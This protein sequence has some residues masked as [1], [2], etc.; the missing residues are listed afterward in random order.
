MHRLALCLLG[1]L[2]GIGLQAA[3]ADK[4]REI[5]LT[6]TNLAGRSSLLVAT[7]PAGFT[8]TIKDMPGSK[9]RWQALSAESADQRVQLLITLMPPEDVLQKDA[10]GLEML[11]HK[12]SAPFVGGSVEG[13]VTPLPLK[14]TH[15]IGVATIFSDKSEVG[16]P[17]AKGR[18]HYK[19][20]T[21]GIIRVGEATLAS[22]TIFSDSKEAAGYLDALKLVASLRPTK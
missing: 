9:D 18:G 8:A 19:L 2:I 7:L 21:H 6:S 13:K 10:A 12:A 17:E 5:S 16:K 20:L 15:G 11:L 22:V 3:E 14:L 1:L 4:P